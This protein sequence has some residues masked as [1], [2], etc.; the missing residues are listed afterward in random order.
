[1][2]N[3]EEITIKVS[4][5]IAQAYRQATTEEQ[6]QM[7]LKI[8]ALMR[9]ALLARGARSQIAYSQRE[10]I[11]QFRKTMDLASQ[12]AESKGLTP[13]MLELILS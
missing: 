1:M 5:D 3:S 7:Q 4:S 8:A 13:E 2:I 10:N 6:E 9:S 12:E 11:E